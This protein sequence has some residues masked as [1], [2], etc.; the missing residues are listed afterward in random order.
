MKKV[1]LDF[2]SVSHSLESLSKDMSK[3]DATEK[4]L[5]QCIALRNYQ[6]KNLKV[7]EAMSLSK[8]ASP[9]TIHR[10]LKNLINLGFITQEFEEANRR[11]KY[12]VPT[13]LTDK[14]F[15]SLGVAMRESMSSLN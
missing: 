6:G 11:T 8:V 13:N 1:Y 2:L 12:L 7:T 4:Y 14:Y 5:L 15:T 10:K 9:A 3:L